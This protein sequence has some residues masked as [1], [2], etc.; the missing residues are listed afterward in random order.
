MTGDHTSAAAVAGAEAR[1]IGLP[2]EVPVLFLV[3]QVVFPFGATQIRIRMQRNLALLE[4]L[5]GPDAV[6]AVAFAPGTEAEKVRAEDIGHVGVAARVIARLKLPD[7]SEHVT[8]QGLHRVWMEKVVRTDPYFVAMA[9]WVVEQRA[10]KTKADDAIVHILEMVEELS[11]VDPSVQAEHVALLRSNVDDP[12]RFADLVAAV[13]AFD[14]AHQRRIVELVDILPRLDYVSTLV[15]EKLEFAR[16]VRETD[17]KVRTDIERSQREFYL[18]RQL[19]VLRDELGETTREEEAARAALARLETAAVPPAVDKIA[20]REIERLRT[21]PSAS[22]E[23]GV[24]ENYLDWLLGMP[25]SVDCPESIDLVE[26][27]RVLDEDHYGLERPKQRILEYLAVRKLAPQARGPVLCFIGP[28][29]TGK[30]S[31][32]QSIARATGRKLARISVGGIRDESEIRGHRRTYVGAMPGRIVDAIRRSG[33]RNPLLVIDEIDKLE[34]G[35]QGDPAAALLEVLD[36]EQNS[37]FVDHYLDVQVDLSRVF[38]VATANYVY[39]IPAPL[40]DRME[41]IELS[42]YIEEEKLEIAVRHLVRRAVER[43]GLGRRASFTRPA[44]R[45]IIRGYT[46]EPGVRDLQRRIESVLRKLA[47]R[48]ARGE[49]LP[50]RITPDVV[51]EVLGPPTFPAEEKRR[52]AEVGIVNGLAWTSAGGDVLLIEGIRFPGDGEIQ[53]TG[54]LGDVMRESVIAAWSY[55]RSRAPALGLDPTEFKK[56]NVH[57][58]FPEGAIPKDG[59]S[60]GVAATVALASLFTGRA[61]RADFAMTGEV[62]LRGKVLPIGGLREKLAAAARL[63]IRNVI[64]PKANE[65]DLH[66]VRDSVKRRLRIFLVDHMDEVLGLALARSRN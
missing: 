6:F 27:E 20:R 51:S 30:T 16:V 32:A 43:T 33:C 22:A 9:A 61:A 1:E 25:W 11:S 29:G 49:K 15:R 5:D 28:P 3:S 12:G 58:H 60:A 48:V 19:K 56:W 39:D 24:I 55:V 10:D 64:V 38:F 26:V 62:T 65:G 53:L 40:L 66:W 50:P 41:V 34:S 59:P 17:V 18:R 63:G 14:V 2:S 52:R 35:I 54:S 47:L 44:L 42:S 37:T 31:L 57:I 45:L 7:G 4:A 46:L 23:F 13:L 8:V 36:P 21:S